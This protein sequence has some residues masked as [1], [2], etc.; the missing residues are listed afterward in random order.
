MKGW[1]VKTKDSRARDD[2]ALFVILLLLQGGDLPM[3]TMAAELHVVFGQNSPQ[4]RPLRVLGG[5]S[6]PVDDRDP[7][8]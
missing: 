1:G 7:L 8:V 6:S 2:D 3:S 5:P 4:Q